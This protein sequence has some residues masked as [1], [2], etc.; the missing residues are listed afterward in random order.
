MTFSDIQQSVFRRLG[1]ADSPAT[2][3]STR[4]K[5]YIN[6]QHRRLL[7]LPG[8]DYLR[9]DTITFASV[10]STPEYA[11]PP[12]IARIVGIRDRT[13]QLVIRPQSWQWYA[14]L[15]TDPTAQTGLSVVWCPRGYTQVAVQPS[16]ASKIYADSTAA[17]DTN[18]VYIEGFRTGGY[19]FTSS[20]TMTGTTAV[21][22]SAYAD[23]ISLT[24]F[25][26]SA[27][28]VGAV[29]LIED[30]EAGTELARIPI[31]KL[32]SRYFTIALWPTPSDAVTYTVDYIRNVE[33]M[34]NATDEPLLP[35]D[36]HWLLATGARMLEY[37][38]QD[39]ARYATAQGEW[40]KGVSDLKWF[41]TQQ[42]ASPRN[43]ISGK[44]IVTDTSVSF[45]YGTFA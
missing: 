5:A 13:N 15:G 44:G 14:E 11:L 43:R 4:I 8:M 7:S 20:E 3:V 30:A 25:Y 27:A 32:Y 16:N 22:V 1:F 29:T 18:T 26:L 19:P 42:A 33:D 23:I 39:D 34:A 41:V 35:S 28:A 9:Q 38:K 10:A 45:D 40:N 21:Q 12:S 6:E 2:D 24:K 37:E 31:G 36:F 17:G